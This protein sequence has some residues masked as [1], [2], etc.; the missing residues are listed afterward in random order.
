MRE[1]MGVLAYK[2]TGRLCVLNNYYIHIAPKSLLQFIPVAD[3]KSIHIHMKA[4]EQVICYSL[5]LRN[6]R[7]VV[8]KIIGE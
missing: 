3:N 6:K 5:P 1:K 7:D 2:K 4:Q 8:V